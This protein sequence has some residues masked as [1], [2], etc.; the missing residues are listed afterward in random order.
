[1]LCLNTVVIEN[2]D[3]GPPTAHACLREAGHLSEIHRD[4]EVC[5]ER[6]PGALATW[7]DDSPILEVVQ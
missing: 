5:W 1:M 2:D 7:A 3:G 4:G 6:H